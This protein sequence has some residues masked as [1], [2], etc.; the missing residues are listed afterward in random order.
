[1]NPSYFVEIAAEAE[2]PVSG[3]RGYSVTTNGDLPDGNVEIFADQ[4]YERFQAVYE[5]EQLDEGVTVVR[6]RSVSNAGIPSGLAGIAYIRLD[7][8]P[9]SIEENGST[10]RERWYS[11][12]L[13]VPLEVYDQPQLSGMIP[14]PEGEPVESGAHVAY[15]LDDQPTVRLRGG[16]AVISI[17]GDGRHTLTYR[18]F[19]AAGNA[20]VQKEAVVRIDGTPPV[21]AFRVLD[22][23]D[24]RQLKVEVAD[25]T[26][27]VADGWI[28]YRRQGESGFRRLATTVDAGV[29]WARLDDDGLPAGRYELRSVVT[30]VAGNEAVIDKWA[31]GSATTLAM[32]LRMG[33]QVEVF[34]S[35]K[36]KRCVKK[37]RKGRAKRLRKRSPRQKCRPA[38]K[39]KKSL[40]LRHGRRATSNGRLTTAQGAPIPGA[41]VL[42]EGQ[43]RSGGAFV[44]LGTARTDTRGGFR[45]IIPAGPSRTIRYRYEGT[46][47]IRS[48]SGTLETKVRA[49]AQLKVNRRRLRN[50]QVVRFSG[51][52]L[53]KPIPRGGK[54][55]AL[56]AKVG[57]K[58]RT[59]A[60]PRANVK[61]V[62]RHRYRFTSTTR[63]RRYAFRAVVAR[64][65]AYPYE[66]GMSPIVRVTVRGR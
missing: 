40:E 54:V 7:R 27:G 18:A 11:G 66:A 25:A 15:E 2:W 28:E 53:G 3:I 46:N 35:A 55:V 43:A 37:A 36:A 41:P 57:R 5:F 4:D 22:P 61:G 23:K 30:D 56:Q 50:G 29:L 49:A 63:L 19:D 42:V 58:W 39:A 45:F 14:A 44:R 59:F 8:T 24:P 13:A 9:P 1:M 60:N 52:L 64:E 65:A 47:T 33:A 31:D 34:A 10:L 12:P 32:P 51:R 48:A 20:S 21:G 17:S 38:A 16:Q 62:F 6:T 26:S